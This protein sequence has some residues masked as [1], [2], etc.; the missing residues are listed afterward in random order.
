MAFG[1]GT[2]VGP[3]EILSAI[4]AGGMGQVYRAT[5]TN[6]G[7]QVAIK[8]LPDTFAQDPERLARFE[9]EAKTLASL[10]HPNIAIIHGV[11]TA[12]D[13][14]RALVME[15]VEGET[16][17]QRIARGPIQLDEVLPLAKQ[18]AEALGAAH[19]QGVVHRDLK[20]ANIMVRP[21]GTVKVLDF[22]LAKAAVGAA[23][24]TASD[25]STTMT[26]TAM[27]EAGVIVGTAAYMSPEQAR[28]KPVDRRADIWAFG[29]LLYEM[30]TAR[31]PFE[32]Q[33]FSLTLSK[34]LRVDPDFDALPV[35][36]PAR[37]RQAL[38]VCLRKDRKD[39]ASD[40]HDVWLALEGAFETLAPE[41]ARSVA[42][43]RPWQRALPIATTAIG[44]VLVTALA[45]WSLWPRVEPQ[46]VNRFDYNLPADQVFRS[47]GRPAM[48]LSPDGRHVVYNTRGGLYLRSMS[49]LEARRIPGTEATLAS[50]F[51]GP[52]GQSIGYYQDGRLKRIGIDGGVPVV[53]CAAGNPFGASWGTDNTILFGQATGIMRVSANGG[54]PELM[55]RAKEGEQ[56]YGPQLLPD[57][58]SVLFSVTTAS[59][60]ARW[61]AAQIVVQSLSTGVRKVLLQGGSDARYVSTGHLVYALGDALL[62]VRF[63]VGR[64]EVERGPVSAVNRVVRAGDPGTN[65]GAANYGISDSGTLVY[66]KSG[67]AL[68]NSGAIGT[69]PT[70]TLVWVDRKRLEEPLAAPPRAYLYPRLSPDGTRLALDIRDQQGDI[71]VWDIRRQTL[72]PFTSG[73]TI[74]MAPVWSPDGQR[75]VWASGR[76]GAYSLYSQAADGTGSADRLTDSPNRQLPYGFTPDRQRLLFAED[77]PGK[78]QNLL[79]LSLERDRPVTRLLEKEFAERNGE[80]SPDGRWLAYE[81]DELGQPEIYVRPFPAV[82]QGVWRI[83][84]NGGREPLWARNGRELF[85]LAP[86]GTLMGVPVDVAQGSASFAWGTAAK[87]IDGGSFVGGPNTTTVGYLLRTYDVSPDGARFLRIK[88]KEEREA[89]GAAQGV[90]VVQ[91]WTEELKRLVPTKSR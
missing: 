77:A 66:V 38:V 58:H 64:L 24:S 73:P 49:A 7:R 18:I 84:L 75:L 10:N 47:T 87:L 19:E 40:I 13:G 8:V 9:R 26:V 37:V 50:P 15:L 30:L 53:I 67:S 28:G 12:A 33:D 14:R 44:A 21:D 63:D 76:T 20:P 61:D 52:D 17:A 2:R 48:A 71:W 91:N 42:A 70:G 32:D 85:Y 89:G 72:T 57:R 25:D 4:A 81:A 22:G 5:D 54:T 16:L 68:W 78:S 39:R 27:T 34:I 36:V 59:G 29:C 51:F 46:P 90:V 56:V 62:A 41:V 88:V 6:L 45:A 83:S 55:I 65:T 31:R 86:D 79:M 74:D 11:E 82:E 43:P 23:S 69:V 1:P 3:Y 60:P 80:I 35:A